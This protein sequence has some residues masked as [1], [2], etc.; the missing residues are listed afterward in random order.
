MITETMRKRP[1][2]FETLRERAEA[3]PAPRTHAEFRA[4]STALRT[5]RRAWRGDPYRM[6]A[7]S[8][9]VDGHHRRITTQAHTCGGLVTI[10]RTSPAVLGYLGLI[11]HAVHMHRQ[12]CTEDRLQDARCFAV[13]CRSAGPVPLPE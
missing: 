7:L 12:G 3:M 4:I 11:R 6:P 1:E 9:L 2:T 5:A 13:A 8:V 10:Y